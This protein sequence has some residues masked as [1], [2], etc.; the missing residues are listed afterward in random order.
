[1]RLFLDYKRKTKGMMRCIQI[2]NC[3]IC[4]LGCRE[5][6]AAM[7]A[8]QRTK[9]E[10]EQ[11]RAEQLAWREREKARLAEEDKYVPDC[12]V[13]RTLLIIM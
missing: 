7:L 11:F 4:T 13:W 9:A 6:E 5:V 10:I 3:L 2:C 1:M 12:Y 8:K